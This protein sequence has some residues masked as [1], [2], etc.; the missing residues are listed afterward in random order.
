LS[1]HSSE[2]QGQRDDTNKRQ[3][4]ADRILDAAQGL[5][6]RYGYRKTT[7]DDI[8]R[9][10]GVAKG[11]IYLHWKTREDLF[12]D[13]LLREKVKIS[14]EVEQEM[15]NDPEGF[16]LYT[17]LKYALQASFRNPLNKAI[18]LRD[19][20]LLGEMVNAAYRE[21]EIMQ[22]FAV[23][24]TMLEQQ[25]EQ[26]LIRADMTVDAQINLIEAVIIGFLTYDQYMPEQMRLNDNE[27]AA[28]AAETLRRTLAL[29]KPDTNT[30]N[31]MQQ[32]YNQL[33]DMVEEYRLKKEHRDEQSH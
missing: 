10:A 14:R 29:E 27:K 17:M 20:D 7:I 12:M 26:G 5:V 25:R 9:Q 31:T 16:S 18:L 11:T 30:Q 1:E 2:T 13:L 3:E 4:R 32:Q 6:L 22:Q 19:S 21:D 33:M 23:F 8:A 24:K 15:L 28:L